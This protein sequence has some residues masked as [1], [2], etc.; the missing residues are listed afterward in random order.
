MDSRRPLRIA[1]IAPVAA[2]VPPP[3]YGGIERVVS[4]LTETLVARGHDVTLFASG[5]SRTSAT[6]ASVFDAALGLRITMSDEAYHEVAAFLRAEEFDLVH[7]HSWFGSYFGAF[8]RSVPV[9]TTVHQP[10]YPDGGRSYRLVDDRVQWV[11]VSDSQRRANAD[12]PWAATIHHGIDLEQHP[13]RADKDDYLVFVGRTI[14]EKAPELAVEVAKRAGRHL[15]MVIKR[16]EPHEVAHWERHVVPVLGGDEEILENA[17]H[18]EKMRCVA[19]AAGLLFPIV[20]DEPFG[21]VM[22][23]AMAC[24]TPVI[25]LA[26]GAAPE[27][28]KHGV[29]G[30]LVRSVD[31]M[32]A[33]VPQLGRLS[34]SACRERVDRL[35][36]VGTMTSRYEDLFRRLTSA[37]SARTTR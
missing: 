19:G 13:F 21:L 27:V 9:V 1:Q 16:Q 8:Q 18:D 3:G 23:E 6:L 22:V 15:K 2:S 5:D 34:P 20:W 33:A 7:D 4:L 10:W 31:E 12:L 29:T 30:F 26:E 24:G 25:A 17:G 28:V 36:S 35:F 14:P 11:A 37:R 32:V